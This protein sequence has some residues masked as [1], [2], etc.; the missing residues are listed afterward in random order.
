MRALNRPDSHPNQISCKEGSD[1]PAPLP[2]AERG[3][4]NR[5]AMELEL[6]VVEQQ[7]LLKRC[8]AFCFQQDHSL[9]RCQFRSTAH[10]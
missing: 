9:S 3:V 7:E 8:K 2:T 10:R 5:A 4:V 6:E 1:F